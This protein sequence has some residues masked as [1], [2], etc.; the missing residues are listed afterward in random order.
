MEEYIAFNMIRSQDIYLA[1][2]CLLI[3]YVISNGMFKKYRKTPI[4]KYILPAITLHFA[5]ALIYTLVISYY[6]GFGDSHNYYQGLLDMHKAVVDDISFLKDIYL[7]P[8]VETSDRLY[9]YFY[10]DAGGFAKYYMLEPRNYNVARFG[11][12]LSLIFNRSFLCISFCISFF[13]FLGSWRIFKMFYE[14]YPHLHKKIAYA[15]LFLPSILFWGVSLLKDPICVG[16][17]GFFIYA[18]YSALIKKE[19]VIS[20]VIIIFVSGFLLMNFKPYILLSLSAVFLLWVFL[21]FRNK[22]A[23]KTLRTVSTTFFITV[24][25]GG[26]FLLSQSLAQTE[27]TDQFSSEKILKTIEAQQ[28]TFSRNTAESEGGG[29]NFSV[30][31]T[32]SPIAM[33]IRLPLGVVNTY[34]RPFLF[35]VRSPVAI[36]SA[37]ES[38]AFLAI[39]FLCFKRIGV[40]KTFNIIFSDPVIAFCFVFAIMFGGL[41]GITTVNF[42]A[43]V[44]YK[45]PSI[46]FYAMAFILVMD[47][48]GKFSRDF[49]FSKKLF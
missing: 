38:F 31:N 1:P 4:K 10:Y 9:A 24:A 3:L 49:I 6:Y 2:L 42:G 16:A 32:S 11:L 46:P 20:S 18:A 39:T 43:L 5:G 21:R 29:S 14:M 48:S 35:E 25:M 22:I 30:G 36:I 40:G 34:F 27:A 33:A 45:I 47:K 8:R 26:G 28:G 12:P 23:D 15:T 7:K 44:R 19:K 41:I 13:S 17:M 37:F